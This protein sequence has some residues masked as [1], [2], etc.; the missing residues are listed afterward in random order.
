[1]FMQ[2]TM[3]QSLVMEARVHSIQDKNFPFV[4]A[5]KDWKDELV[6]GCLQFVKFIQRQKRTLHPK[7]FV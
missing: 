4:Q 3:F 5:S 1:M 7:T 2:M 6:V